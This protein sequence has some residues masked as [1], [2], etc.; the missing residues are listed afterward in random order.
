MATTR[1]G[2][3]RF[4]ICFFL[5]SLTLLPQLAGILLGT[6][7]YS[8]RVS[9]QRPCRVHAGGVLCRVHPLGPVCLCIGKS[10]PSCLVLPQGMA[11]PNAVELRRF[12]GRV[13]CI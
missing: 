1:L 13:A 11:A 3:A 7:S 8:A 4:S 6:S 12:P 5:P 10:S 9:L 2:L